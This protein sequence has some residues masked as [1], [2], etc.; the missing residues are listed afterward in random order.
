MIG[1]GKGMVV[2]RIGYNELVV[3]AKA[4]MVFMEYIASGGAYKIESKW[5]SGESNGGRGHSIEI[6]EPAE[7]EIKNLPLERVALAK[8]NTATYQ[9]YMEEKE[10]KEKS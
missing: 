5:M 9:Q 4:A 8:L 7:I 1:D 10:R 2:L 6:V 3:P